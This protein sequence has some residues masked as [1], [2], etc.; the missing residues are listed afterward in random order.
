MTFLFL[1]Q[2]G[3][4][5]WRTGANKI[6]QSLKSSN[7]FLHSQLA[8]AFSISDSPVWMDSSTK[9]ECEM[10]EEAVGGALAGRLGGW[11]HLA[12]ASSQTA[13]SRHLTIKAP[14]RGRGCLCWEFKSVFFLSSSILTS[15]Y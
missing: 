10:L 2:H 9:T 7:G 4:V 6:L 13:L 3:S 12:V 5:Y 11:L 14:L 1:Q 15:I 8:N